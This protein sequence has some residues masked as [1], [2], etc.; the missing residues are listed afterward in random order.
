[1]IAR[2]DACIRGLVFSLR[3]IK[4]MLSGQEDCNP[5][6]SC[7]PDGYH[8]YLLFCLAEGNECEQDELARRFSFI[9]TLKAKEKK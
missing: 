2:H 1:M 4:D 5:V 7:D 8:H 3:V 6:I 9:M